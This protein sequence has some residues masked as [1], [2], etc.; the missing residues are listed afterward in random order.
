M[1]HTMKINSLFLVAALVGATPAVCPLPS[2]Q[3]ENAQSKVNVK[4]PV[5]GLKIVYNGQT[6]TLSGSLHG[7][8]SVKQQSDGAFIKGHFNAQGI[9]VSGSDGTSYRGVGAGNFQVRTES[10]GATVKGILNIGLIGQ[11]QD[12]N[13]RLK[14]RLRGT[15][16]AN[17]QVQLSAL[18]ATLSSK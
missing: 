12:P 13:V 16:D 18:D 7:T 17:G 3:A 6:Y 11:G 5:D 14:V 9:S 10:D 15:V 1:I 8:L 4:V 2:A